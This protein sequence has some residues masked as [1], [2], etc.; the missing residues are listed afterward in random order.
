VN[1]D[2]TS[3][4]KVQCLD[5]KFTSL[6]NRDYHLQSGSPAVD[7][8]TANGLPAG[9]TA[10]INN[11]LAVA[12]GLPS[13]SDNLPLVGAAW[14][15]GAVEARVAGPPTA[16]LTITP[17]ASAL[18]RGS[19]SISLTASTS[20]VAVPGPLTFLESDLSTQVITLSGAI[21]GVSFAGTF[22]VGS[23]V[24]DGP[25]TF[26]LPANSLV[27]SSGLQGNQ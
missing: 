8:G 2:G 11:T 24:A 17:S 23:S 4:D 21:P 27:A 12:H 6:S 19:Y 20:L 22:V 10:S 1:G 3:N 16:A 5:P 7:A 9:R 13:Y 18:A 14:D 15:T 26:S 25:G